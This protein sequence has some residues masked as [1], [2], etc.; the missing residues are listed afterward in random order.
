MIRQRLQSVGCGG[1]LGEMRIYLEIQ[2]ISTMNDLICRFV[3]SVRSDM[4]DLGGGIWMRL[5]EL[6]KNYSRSQFFG[7][8]IHFSS[9]RFRL[10]F[11]SSQE[12]HS[13]KDI[14]QS[15]RLFS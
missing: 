4:T 12:S 10:K 1:G 11:P 6:T 14:R 9:W 8:V 3:W 15:K 13:K 7:I 2:E 5:G